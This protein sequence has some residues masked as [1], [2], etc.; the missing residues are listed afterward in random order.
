MLTWVTIV[1]VIGFVISVFLWVWDD[2]GEKVSEKFTIP[3]IFLTG[4]AVILSLLFIAPPHVFTHT[5][6]QILIVLFFVVVFIFLSLAEEEK[7]R[8]ILFGSALSV[9]L[10]IIFLDQLLPL[11]YL[12]G[13][14]HEH[15]DSLTAEQLS[16]EIGRKLPLTLEQLVEL[17]EAPDLFFEVALFGSFIEWEVISIVFG[18]SLLVAVLSDTG[19]FDMVSIRTIKASQGTPKRLLVLVFFL[20]LILS[21]LLDNTTAIILLSSI[22]I[23]V[24][25]GLDLNPKPYI[26]AEVAATVM[27]GIIT[28]IGSLPGILIASKKAGNI[29]FMT[30]S[31][32]NSVFIG[33]AIAIS[34][35]YIFLI[36]KKELTV[37]EDMRIDPT[38]VSFLDEWSVVDS[39]RK[40]YLGSVVLGF[41]VVGL[42]LSSNI[43]LSVG[44]V[45][46][47]GAILAIIITKADIDSVIHEIELDSILFFIGLFVLVGALQ[48]SGVLEVLAQIMLQVSGGDPLILAIIIITVISILSAIVANIPITIA[49]AEVIRILLDNPE[50]SGQ[51]VFGFPVGGLLW[52]TLL[53][54]VTF[55]GGFTPFGTVTGVIG[56]QVLQ[57]EGHPVT[58]MDYVKKMAP[59][60][61]VLLVLGFIYL[62][63]L[64]LTGI[65]PLLLGQ[66]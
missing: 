47:T 53:Y 24:T 29:P 63:I 33:V 31:L 8:V 19:L 23:T 6:V 59:L 55:G 21:A 27:A 1:S 20:T 25:R 62:L 2:K 7:L 13:L 58:F 32:V 4:I 41:V 54:A 60:S 66:I 11:E 44:F 52:F 65:L 28:V 10:M 3:A 37:T 45:A 17:A 61:A 46:I 50:F 22:T 51:T 64:Q 43:G 42:V 57:Q 18:M 36:F 14:E 26:L 38:I 34:I 30:F 5:E 40:L 9:M 15:L 35:G 56:V 16:K 48:I 12:R 39:R 49:L